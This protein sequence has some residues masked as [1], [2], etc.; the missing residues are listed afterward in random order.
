MIGII[1]NLENYCK[2]WVIRRG[3]PISGVSRL[4]NVC[5]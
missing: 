4:Q 3:F 5:F 2:L 1:P